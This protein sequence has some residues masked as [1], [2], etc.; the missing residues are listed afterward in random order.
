MPTSSAPTLETSSA[1]I[2]VMRGPAT[3]GQPPKLGDVRC[4]KV[5]GRRA[6]APCDIVGDGSDLGVGIR[7]REGG[8]EQ[9]ALGREPIRA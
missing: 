2:V 7:G 4:R 5:R 6:K 1:E 9:H 3:A 8:H